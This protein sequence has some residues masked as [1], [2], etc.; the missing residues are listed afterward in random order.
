MQKLLIKGT[1]FLMLIFSQVVVH[2]QANEFIIPP[3]IRIEFAPSASV[4]TLP[5]TST[6]SS[7]GNTTNGYNERNNTVIAG[8]AFRERSPIQGYSCGTFN[9]SGKKIS[10]QGYSNVFPV[11]GACKR[12]YALGY[13]RQGIPYYAL[14]LRKL[15]I[16]NPDTVICVDSVNLAYP[17]DYTNNYT[18]IAIAPSLMMLPGRYM[19]IR[20]ILSGLSP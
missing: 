11:P 20:T 14:M 3:N 19:S 9:L 7:C 18:S 1:T 15:D 13:E 10:T 17:A 5:S 12:L 8:Y 6:Y 16:S 4:T 2:A